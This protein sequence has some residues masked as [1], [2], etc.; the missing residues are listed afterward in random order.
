MDLE[1]ENLVSVRLPKTGSAATGWYLGH[2]S[3]SGSACASCANPLDGAVR[4]GC[5]QESSDDRPF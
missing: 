4:A 5:V 2:L 3:S 1:A